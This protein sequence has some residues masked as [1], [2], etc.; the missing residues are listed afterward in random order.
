MGNYRENSLRISNM[1]EFAYSLPRYNS[2]LGLPLSGEIFCSLDRTMRLTLQCGANAAPISGKGLS[3]RA[4][5]REFEPRLPGGFT[6]SRSRWPAGESRAYDC[7]R[8]CIIVYLLC[9]V[10]ATS[11][12]PLQCDTVWNTIPSSFI[13]LLVCLCVCAFVARIRASPSG[14]R[15]SYIV[16]DCLY[17]DRYHWPV[18]FTIRDVY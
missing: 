13:F 15:I 9:H 10:H 2:W 16:F 4:A 5:T 8:A 12:A 18:K 6:L 1:I 3:A 14:A 7:R 11:S 17:R